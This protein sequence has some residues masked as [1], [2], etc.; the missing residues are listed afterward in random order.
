MVLPE[1]RSDER[2]G[3]VPMPLAEKRLRVAVRLVENCWPE[4]YLGQLLLAGWL[5]PAIH[6]FMDKVRVLD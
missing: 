1:V 2:S 5:A 4:D 6:E 3:S